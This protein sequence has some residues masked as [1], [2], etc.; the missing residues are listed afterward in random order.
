M[1]ASDL[2]EQTPYDLRRDAVNVQNVETVLCK[3]F[4]V[5]VDIEETLPAYVWLLPPSF[6]R[7]SPSF[8]AA[9]AACN[10]K[11]ESSREETIVVLQRTYS[12]RLL[13]YLPIV[14]RILRLLFAANLF[15]M[16]VRLGRPNH[17]MHS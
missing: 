13:N 8:L 9:M 4:S 14:L 2:N 17:M 6:N 7:T 5:D 15:I 3:D 10:A 1:F 16:M 11:I 12:N